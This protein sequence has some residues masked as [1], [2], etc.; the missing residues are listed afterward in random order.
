MFCIRVLFCPGCL[1]C[2]LRTPFIKR[3]AEKLNIVG[4]SNSP[5]LL[6]A[7]G[8]VCRRCDLL[9]FLF[10]GGYCL[11]EVRGDAAGLKVGDVNPLINPVFGNGVTKDGSR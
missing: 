5:G 2:G 7:V 8:S 11:S 10:L 4:L 9:G 6:S 1:V 3:S